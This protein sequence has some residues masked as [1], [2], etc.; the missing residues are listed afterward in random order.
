[1]QCCARKCVSVHVLVFLHF[2]LCP[3]AFFASILQCWLMFV[4]VCVFSHSHDF[5]VAT[6][7]ISSVLFVA[8]GQLLWCLSIYLTK[9]SLNHFDTL[10]CFDV[11][12]VCF[13]LSPW[14]SKMMRTIQ[15]NPYFLTPN[16]VMM[17]CERKEMLQM[18]NGK[19]FRQNITI[20][21]DSVC[22]DAVHKSNI[23]RDIT[24]QAIINKRQFSFNNFS[25]VASRFVCVFVWGTLQSVGVF[26]FAPLHS[27]FLFVG[28]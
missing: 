15:T 28:A 2:F 10:F 18:T 5:A 11:W 27:F 16:N 22:L 24:M 7:H 12:C 25:L 13:I 9:I 14:F 1:M 21:N 26:F 3:F 23:G 19:T 6:F 17:I 4:C 8:G 20:R